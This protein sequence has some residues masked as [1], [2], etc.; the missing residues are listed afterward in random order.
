VPRRIREVENKVLEILK[1]VP[2]TR[3]D[4]NLLL[5][6][7]LETLE[8]FEPNNFVQSGILENG[9]ATKFKSVERCRRKLQADKPELRGKRWEKR[10]EAQESFIEYS[11]GGESFE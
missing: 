8:D 6:H 10:H 3:D 11:K 5:S 7:Y 9:I 1:L 2:E 4:D